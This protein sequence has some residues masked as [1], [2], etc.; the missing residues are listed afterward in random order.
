M[1]FFRRRPWSYRLAVPVLLLV[2]GAFFL[3][4]KEWAN[5]AFFA[6]LPLMV[7]VPLMRVGTERL[8]GA[9]WRGSAASLTRYTSVRALPSC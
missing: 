7:A 3:L 4:K 6:L 9:L 1:A 2:A 8:R 5:A